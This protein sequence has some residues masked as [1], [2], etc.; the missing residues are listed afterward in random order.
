MTHLDASSHGSLDG[1]AEVFHQVSSDIRRVFYPLDVLMQKEMSER[2]SRAEM[3][4]EQFKALSRRDRNEYIGLKGRCDASEMDDLPNDFATFWAVIQQ[5]RTGKEKYTDA[6]AKLG[7]LSYL[8][9]LDSTFVSSK[10]ESKCSQKWEKLDLLGLHKKCDDI[11]PAFQ[12]LS[13]RMDGCESQTEGPLP[14][15]WK[16]IKHPQLADK[17]PE[18][19]SE[20]DQELFYHNPETKK[21][22]WERPGV[23]IKGEVRAMY[24]FIYKYEYDARQLTDIVRTSF[25]FKDAPSLWKAV[26][27]IDN[28]F[29]ADGGDGILRMKD[30]LSNPTAAGNSDVLLNVRYKK[31]IVCEIQLHLRTLYDLKKAGGHAAYKKARHFGAYFDTICF[32]AS[33]SI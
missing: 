12:E 22:Q 32:G 5:C 15:P 29:K 7:D 8:K 9:F 23:P 25:I 27:I 30:R 18:P 11:N 14:K 20:K 16:A 21:S 10:S 3:W 2:I 26:E 17:V 24:K 6:R 1:A 33:P 31:D 4:E 19:G 28:E 13:T